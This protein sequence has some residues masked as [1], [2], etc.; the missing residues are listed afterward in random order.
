MKIYNFIISGKCPYRGENINS[1]FKNWK[2]GPWVNTEKNKTV[3]IAKDNEKCN[4]SHAPSC[5]LTLLLLNTSCPVLANS[6]GP[7]Q[8]ASEEAN[9]FG[10]AQ[11]VIKY[12]IPIKNPDQIIWLAGN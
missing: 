1:K 8:L 7:D 9:W 5:T 11:F 10:S 12:G 2:E 6:V 3:K 4:I